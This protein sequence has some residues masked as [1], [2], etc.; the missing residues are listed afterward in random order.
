VDA[1]LARA[2]GLLAQGQNAATAGV[3]AAFVAFGLR[4]LARAWR[5]TA[6]GVPALLGRLLGA[7]AFLGAGVLYATFTLPVL[8]WDATAVVL[9]ALVALLVL[10][11]TLLAARRAQV[12]P[13]TSRLPW[14]WRA[15]ASLAQV[16]LLLALLLVAALTLMRAGFLSLTS[17]RPVLL[18][19]VTGETAVERV[20]WAAP[21]EP[22][23]EEDLTT[24]RVRLRA[25][26]GAPVGELWLYGDQVAIK[27][28]VLRLSP[29]LNAAGVPNLFEL[30]FA[31]NGWATLERHAAYPHVARALRPVG[32]LAVHPWWRG[33]QR[34]LLEAFSAA[35]EVNP[36]AALERGA[37]APRT[38]GPELRAAPEVNSGAAPDAASPW[39]VRAVATEST[40]FALVAADGRPVTR[41]YRLV[42]TPGGLT[43]GAD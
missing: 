30:Q 10:V 1:A 43:A 28:R 11:P 26:D 13:A 23:R 9:A 15:G 2:L 33:L 14:S 21:G 22:L 25:P 39:I 38:P 18:L 42:L 5:G 36:G 20:R 35:P 17:D 34:R 37:P 31:H 32:P 41:V 4:F 12:A 16:A 6:D 24:H 29:L 19:D 27:G 7:G 40:Y 8:S 3:L